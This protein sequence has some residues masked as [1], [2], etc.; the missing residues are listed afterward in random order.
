M[1]ASPSARLSW[2]Q[3]I[4]RNA[5]FLWLLG[6]SGLAWAW[7]MF[8]WQA[9]PFRLPGWGLWGLVA[10]TMLSL[11]ATIDADQLR[12]LRRRPA[13]VLLGVG[14]QC[15][16]MP[17]LAW[18]VVRMLQLDGPMAGGV[19]LVGCV[20]GAMASNVLTLLSRG[21]VSYSI[22]LTTVATLLAPVTVPLL[23]TVLAHVSAEDSLVDPWGISRTLV[24]TIVMPVAIGY[25]AKER[26]PAVQPVAQ[27]WAPR[28]AACALLWIIAS[29]VAGNRERLA[30]VESAMLLG[31]VVINL[32]GYAGGW[33]VG[34]LTR[35]SLPMRKAL[36]LEIG[37]QNAG[38]GTALAGTLYGAGSAAQ[39]P[40]A[41][42]TF[43]CMFTG[44]VLAGWWNHR[45]NSEGAADGGEGVRD[46]AS[47][48]EG[49]AIGSGDGDTDRP[50]DSAARSPV[51]PNSPGGG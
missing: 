43:G 5:L 40:T 17:L 41:A 2:R 32:S 28:A 47:R 15:T 42:Y 29:V 46:P 11:G 25:I 45:R 9:D 4:R 51:E 27:L 50:T 35:M 19:V 34:R 37:M 22:C 12:E 1:D 48:R 49:K 18:S 36:T 38:L 7:P 6:T 44:T 24:G 3:I 16:W 13:D 26:L 30:H 33:A 23:L 21:N 20:P 31:L 8:G 14:V 39:I 10:V